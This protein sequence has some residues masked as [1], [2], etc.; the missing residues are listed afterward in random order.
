MFRITETLLTPNTSIPSYR[1][2]CLQLYGTAAVF[3][4]S[5]DKFM[6]YRNIEVFLSNG[7][8]IVATMTSFPMSQSVG[9]LLPLADYIT[10]TAMLCG[11]CK[12]RRQVTNGRCHVCLPYEHGKQQ[13]FVTFDSRHGSVDLPSTMT[14]NIAREVESTLIAA[15]DWMQ[16][17]QKTLVERLKEIS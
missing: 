5:L 17:E 8:D 10:S 2:S 7:V 1:R 14:A 16:E 9:D 6:D 12:T 4:D 3:I 13:R 11:L 15:I